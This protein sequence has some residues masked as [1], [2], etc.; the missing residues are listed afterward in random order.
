MNFETYLRAVLYINL[1]E[2][3]DEIKENIIKKILEYKAP[4]V[5]LVKLDDGSVKE[6]MC[7]WFV[8]SPT[9]VV[10]IGEPLPN[11]DEINKALEKG[12][13]YKRGYEDAKKEYSRPQGKWKRII[14]EYNDVECPF[15]GFQEDGIYYNFC[16]CCG[17]D[18]MKGSVE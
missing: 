9:E 18:M 14:D 17:A 13:I 1:T 7:S 2:V 15:C 16:P 3:K 8:A 11:S 4:T 6:K 10:K 12:E 5:E